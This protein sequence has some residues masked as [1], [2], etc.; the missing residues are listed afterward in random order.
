VSIGAVLALG[1]SRRVQRTDL[2]AGL[3]LGAILLLASCERA[4]TAT[5]ASQAAASAGPSEAQSPTLT[6]DDQSAGPVLFVA[7]SNETEAAIIFPHFTDSTLGT[8][9]ALDTGEVGHAKADLFAR[10]G[11]IGTAIIVPKTAGVLGGECTAWPTATVRSLDRAGGGVPGPWTVGFVTGHASAIP[12]DSMPMLSPADSAHRA[13]DI[14]RVAASLTNDTAPA[15]KGLPFELQHAGRFSIAPGIDGMAAVLVR[16]VNE[17]ANPRE[18]HV[19]LIAERDSTRSAEWTAAY[20]ER[21]SGSEDDLETNDVLAVVRLGTGRTPTIVLSRD[22]GDGGV[23]SLIEHAAPG[24]WRLRWS[25][26]YTGC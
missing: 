21:E 9:S 26:A 12:M 1:A 3:A 22:Y 5:P 11:A 7:G 24:Q 16:H 25:S 17:E 8:V 10:A 18:E 14:A 6:W 2:G 23:Y 4:H 20:S 19:F 15:F 13:A